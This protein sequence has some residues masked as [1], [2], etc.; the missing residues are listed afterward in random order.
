MKIYLLSY[1]T[2]NYRF[3]QLIL[4][5]SAGIFGC[6]RFVS[7]NESDLKKSEFYNKNKEI[8]D[9][10]RGA[11]YWLWK[12]HFLN[13]LISTIKEGDIIVYSDSAIFIRRSLKP[14]FKILIESTKGVLLFHNN[15]KNRFWT[16]RDCFIELGCDSEQFY[17][18][19]LIFGGLQIFQKNKFSQQFIAE[20]LNASQK[21]NIITDSPNKLGKE[22]L[23]GFIE[24][25]HDQSVTSLIAHKNK[26]KLYPD[27]SQFK[28]KD[29]SYEFP[30]E[31]ILNEPLYTSTVFVHRKTGF[32]LLNFSTLK[33]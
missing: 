16:K 4:N 15:Y 17:D 30:N 3:S 13:E 8:L 23:S 9:Q 26:L 24:H 11:G 10:P 27:P 18:T 32:K 21:N 5:L 29:I 1:A 19:P 7:K 14:L 33:N 28:T 12:Y 2:P 25:R 22:N 6:N 20:V 31:I